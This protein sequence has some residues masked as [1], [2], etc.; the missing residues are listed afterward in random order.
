[1]IGPDDRLASEECSVGQCSCTWMGNFYI[2]IS[3]LTVRKLIAFRLSPWDV[4]ELLGACIMR[5]GSRR[6]G[7]RHPI[8]RFVRF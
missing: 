5:M 3:H 2:L 6:H 8:Q 4:L 1:M 7:V